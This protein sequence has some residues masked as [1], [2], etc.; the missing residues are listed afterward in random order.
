M[1][2]SQADE[3][4]LLKERDAARVL[5]ISTRTLQAWRTRGVGPAF[6]RIGRAVRYRLSAMMEFMNSNTHQ[7]GHAR[8]K[9]KASRAKPASRSPKDPGLADD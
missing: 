2:M 6:V 5:T 8:A 3:D 1:A 9:E 7:P 4:P